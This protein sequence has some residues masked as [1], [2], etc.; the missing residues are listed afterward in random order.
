[1]AKCPQGLEPES[2]EYKKKAGEKLLW[3]YGT[4]TLLLF[5]SERVREVLNSRK[6]DLY[7]VGSFCIRLR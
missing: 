2:E 1:M 4:T 6:L 7:F 5:L 3:L